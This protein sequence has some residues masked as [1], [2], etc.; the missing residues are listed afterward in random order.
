MED[1]EAIML[2]WNLG[3]AL[4]WLAPIQSRDHREDFGRRWKDSNMNFF[5]LPS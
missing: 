5:F 3:L 4:R 2:L 1:F